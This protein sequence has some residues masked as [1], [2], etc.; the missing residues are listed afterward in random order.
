M[1]V[2][3]ITNFS[4]F[5][6][7]NYRITNTFNSLMINKK[8]YH[9]SGIKRNEQDKIYSD[10]EKARN[11]IWIDLELTGLNIEQDS[12]LEIACLVTNAKLQTLDNGIEVVI[13]QPESVLNK[14]SHWSAKIHEE[15]W[16]KD[17]L[18]YFCFSKF[19]S[20]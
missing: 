17:N 6:Q 19:V 10:L 16:R 9:V 2:K 15:V 7:C 13:H 3:R 18:N 20:K 11:L 4:R 8:N 5:L 14:M 12:I 1:L